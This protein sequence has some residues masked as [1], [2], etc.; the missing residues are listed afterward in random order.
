MFVGYGK[1]TGA[2]GVAVAFV[3]KGYVMKGV[4]VYG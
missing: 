2:Y 3:M 4:K 1:A